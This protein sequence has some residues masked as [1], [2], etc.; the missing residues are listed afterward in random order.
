METR[1]AVSATR[2]NGR[3]ESRTMI[4][5]STAAPSRPARLTMMMAMVRSLTVEFASFSGS[6]VMIAL[7]SP[8]GSA[9][10]ITRYWPRSS[11][12]MVCMRPSTGM[13]SSVA[14]SLCGNAGGRVVPFW[15]WV[16]VTVLLTI[17]APS[18]PI[19]WP[20]ACAGPLPSGRGP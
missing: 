20:W 6:P 17:S 16:W 15:I 10:A 11:S 5:P 3:S 4:V 19:A 2:R 14:L 12:L 9:V 8:S 18:V 7:P 1:V 13:A